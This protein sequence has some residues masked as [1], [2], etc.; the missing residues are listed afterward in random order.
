MVLWV[1]AN[2][3]SVRVLAL[4]KKDEHNGL[5]YARLAL[6]IW[7]QMFYLDYSSIH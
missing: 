4:H 7:Q 2:W 5:L 6:V 1:Q 3:F